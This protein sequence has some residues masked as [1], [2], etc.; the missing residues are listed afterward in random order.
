[1]LYT[2]CSPTHP[3]APTHPS[4]STSA[5]CV[6]DLFQATGIATDH[7]RLCAS[8]FWLSRVTFLA[9]ECYICHSR[10]QGSPQN[11]TAS[12]CHIFC[13][14]T[15][16]F[17]PTTHPVFG[18]RAACFQL[19]PRSRDWRQQWQQSPLSVTTQERDT[20]AKNGTCEGLKQCT[21]VAIGD[22]VLW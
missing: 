17:Q 13:L 1:M 19:V 4:F 12:T 11:I 21:E 8:N 3:P 22:D 6:L 15:S 7:H 5:H 2:E 14:C 20:E 10:L 9:S 18:L 16:C